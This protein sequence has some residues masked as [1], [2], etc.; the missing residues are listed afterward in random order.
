MHRGV[1][2]EVGVAVTH[3]GT[4]PTLHTEIKTCVDRFESLRLFTRIVELGSFTRAAGELGIP[5]ATATHAIKALEARLGARL[6]ERTTRQVCTTL[7][8]QAYYDRCARL[9]A[10]LEEVESS[11]ANLAEDPRGIVRLDLPGMHATHIVLP[12]L[13]EFH[14]RYPNI[15][16]VI[17]HSG[18]RTADLVREGVDCF[19]RSDSVNDAAMLQRRLAQSTDVL[20]AS[21]DYLKRCGAPL[22]PDELIRH[23]AV[24]CIARN[25]DTVNPFTLMVAGERQE[26][27][28]RSTVSVDDAEACIACAVRGYG[29]VQL[30]QFQVARELREGALVR[31]LP[32][33]I[34][35]SRQISLLCPNSRRL[36]SRVRVLGEWLE[37]VYAQA[38]A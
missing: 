15:E 8:G 32:T 1:R 34:S 31:V 6:L 22:H 29:I 2:R 14:R 26:Y 30:P 4:H 35:P 5:R 28:L 23:I 36:P 12:R 11:L 3:C 13:G 9:L 18:G 17:G 20:C 25:R 7:D 16:L 27:R 33:W 37:G 19:V 24:G 38:F 21:P 10:E